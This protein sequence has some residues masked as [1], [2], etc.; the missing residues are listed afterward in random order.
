MPPTPPS[1]LE[2]KSSR[3][4]VILVLDGDEQIRKLLTFH[5]RRSGCKVLQASRG[6]QALEL[7]RQ[8]LHVDLVL[9]DLQLAGLEALR[10]INRTGQVGSIIVMTRNGTVAEATAAMREGAYDF[11][12]KTNS[13]DEVD[14]SIRNALATLGL[15][16]ELEELKAQL[17]GRDQA[18]GAIIGR[19]PAIAQVL[20][21][22]R[23]V[24]DSD[25][26]VLILGESGSGKELV[27]RAIHEQGQ[28]RD[29][30]F[31]ALNCAAIPESLL[32]SELFG[33]EKGAF[34]GATQRR[35]GKFAEA[36][37]GT[38]FL[39][40]IGELGPALQAKL[41]RVLQTKEIQPIGGQPTR[42]HVRIISATN[43]DL[44]VLVQQGR[45]RLDLYY[46]LAV[47]PI[48]IPPLR[49]RREDIPLLLDHFLARFARQ[50][51]KGGLSLHPEVRELLME[52]PWEGNVRELENMIYRAVVL[53]ESPELT[54]AD[55]PMLA[56][57]AARRAAPAG[58]WPVPPGAAAPGVAAPRWTHPGGA[59]TAPP[60]SQP[61]ALQPAVPQP[62]PPPAPVAVLPLDALEQQAI[63]QAL[64]RNGGN[65]SKAAIQLGI[66]RATLYRKFKKYGL[67]AS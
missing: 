40:E 19:S 41:L 3:P 57:E 26:T 59:P 34:T 5:L 20:K 46:R 15:K 36:H 28:T 4:P 53:A 27:A 13:F 52:H 31:I 6:E 2:R 54:L 8:S 50:E 60:M 24:R 7:I 30:P 62:A 32:E 51:H 58:P 23:K 12:N 1:P 64:A 33:H 61:P 17:E 11:V 37:E 55:F 21:L 56:L 38:L 39:D 35:V 10:A 63:A 49:E 9:L 45:F 22:A 65:M 16:R 25:I 44:N 29:R 18:F 67:S 43:Q 14:V 47:F 48:H 66:G 42:I